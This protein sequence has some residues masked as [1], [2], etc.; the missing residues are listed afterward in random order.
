MLAVVAVV[1]SVLLVVIAPVAVTVALVNVKPAIV[2]DVPPNDVEVEPIVIELFANDEFGMELNRADAIVP[3]KLAA[4]YDP[5][6]VAA[7]IV[8]ADIVDVDPRYMFP[9][10]PPNDVEVEPIVIVL[11]ANE[12]FGM[13][14]KFPVA[15]APLTCD[16][17]TVP[18]KV[19]AEI[20]PADIVDDVPRYMFPTVP[21]NDVEVEPIV[22]ELFA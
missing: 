4:S 8:P 2:D 20:V 15:N 18:Y 10:V 1:L 19:A 13:E 9:T 11:L 17:A 6:K 5:Y 16:A 3:V 22:I 7:E 14:G 21:P 12:L